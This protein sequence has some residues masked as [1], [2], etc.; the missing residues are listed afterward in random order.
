MERKTTNKLLETCV[1]IV[2]IL[3]VLVS[4][5]LPADAYGA[6]NISNRYLGSGSYSNSNGSVA[7]N[8]KA[9]VYYNSNTSD[10]LDVYSLSET[11]T[12]NGTEEITKA[13]FEVSDAQDNKLTMLADG[14][15]SVPIEGGERRRLEIIWSE[16]CGAYG[17]DDTVYEKNDF[18]Y[19]YI[20]A[21]NTYYQ[22]S[23]WASYWYSNSVTTNFLE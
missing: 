13:D 12:N 22:E 6:V 4:W 7:Y 15:L 14:N 3:C 10:E 8:I 2:L 16:V 5:L 21:G 17:Y 1:T 9:Y 19:V 18:V 11:V 23:G 20:G